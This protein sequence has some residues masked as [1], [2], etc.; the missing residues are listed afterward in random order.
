M[1]DKSVIKKITEKVF[2][3]KWGHKY[4]L[5]KDKEAYIEETT[6]IEGSNAL[7]R[8]TT[9]ISNELQQLIHGVGCQ[10]TNNR[11]KIDS[12]LRYAIKVFAREN[13]EEENSEG[14]NRKMTTGKSRFMA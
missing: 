1:N 3:N 12:T 9:A 7:S 5:L 11:I 8:F 6:E 14:Q 2:K 10:D 13:K 4:Y